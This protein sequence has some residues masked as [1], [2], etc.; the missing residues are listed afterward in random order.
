MNDIQMGEAAGFLS[1]P[2]FYHVRA[3]LK[4]NPR[5]KRRLFLAIRFQTPLTTAEYSEMAVFSDFRGVGNLDAF[6]LRPEIAVRTA[7]LPRKTSK[8]NKSK[9]SNRSLISRSTSEQSQYTRLA[10]HQGHGASNDQLTIPFSLDIKS[11]KNDAS[12]DSDTHYPQPF[13]FQETPP[14]RRVH[15]QFTEPFY[16]QTDIHANGLKS[17]EERNEPSE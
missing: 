13:L 4:R 16:V 1:V 14:V 17:K 7:V 15:E 9:T 5:S 6:G 12:N 3:W 10:G 11:T 8:K 2:R